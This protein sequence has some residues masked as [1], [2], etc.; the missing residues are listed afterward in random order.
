MPYAKYHKKKKEKERNLRRKNNGD[1]LKYRNPT[2][3][4][5]SLWNKGEH[6]PRWKGGVSKT[7]LKGTN[8]KEYI[9]WRKA[10]V[11]RDNWTCQSCG[12][13]GGSLHAHHIKLWKD[14]PELR[15]VVD[16]GITLCIECHLDL[17]FERRKK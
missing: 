14:Y 1:F 12:K 13:V 2:L 16:N 15:Y 17:H 8:C 9:I 7:R 3:I 4:D 5:K 6:N 11:E 10:V